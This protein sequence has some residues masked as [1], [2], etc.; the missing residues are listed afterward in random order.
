MKPSQMNANDRNLTE[1]ICPKCGKSYSDPPALSR[2]DNETEIC[3]ECGTREA[4][5]DAGINKEKQEK[6]IA[7]I[8]KTTAGN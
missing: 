3:P 5:D 2:R 1:R 7:E 4:M 6:I 8:K